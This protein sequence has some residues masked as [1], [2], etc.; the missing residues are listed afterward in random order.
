MHNNPT[1]IDENRSSHFWKN[2]IFFFLC[3]LPSILRVDR[4]RKN[5]LEI[6]ER[7]PEISNVN[8]IG[9]LVYTLR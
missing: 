8:E 1:K 4:K 6:F 3:E 2:K 5:E 7:G 9:K